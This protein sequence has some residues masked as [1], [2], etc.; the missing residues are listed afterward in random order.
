MQESQIATLSNFKKIQSGTEWNTLWTDRIKGDIFE[1]WS[2]FISELASLSPLEF[3]KK[4][5]KQIN[6]YRALLW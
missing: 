4:N 6:P 5:A 3:M 2:G 1:A